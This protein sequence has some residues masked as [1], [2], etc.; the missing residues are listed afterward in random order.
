[1]KNSLLSD[2]ETKKC[3]IYIGKYRNKAD[4]KTNRPVWAIA[5]TL[6]KAGRLNDIIKMGQEVQ[7]G[8]F[9]SDLQ[10]YMKGT[11]PRQKY[12]WKGENSESDVFLDTIY[13]I[14][15]KDS[16]VQRA[17]VKESTDLLWFVLKVIDID[18]NTN[19]QFSLEE[20]KKLMIQRN[21]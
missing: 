13:S 9:L 19:N 14:F 7:K 5:Y 21:R 3:Y 11:S 17:V 10:T 20:L 4:Q 2:P 12:T 16:M 15:N 18:N 1:M 6:M 8:E